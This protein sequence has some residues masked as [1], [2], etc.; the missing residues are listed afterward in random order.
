VTMI[1]GDNGIG[2]PPDLDL[3]KTGSLGLKLV[4]VLV[5]Q[6]DGKVKLNDNGGAE[7]EITFAASQG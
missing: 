2:L 6:L 1:I 5:N 7:F 4:N 3:V